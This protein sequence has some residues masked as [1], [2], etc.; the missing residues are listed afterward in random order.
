[1]VSL[2][3]LLFEG[4]V[5]KAPSCS[6]YMENLFSFYS[7]IIRLKSI[8]VDVVSSAHHFNPSIEYTANSMLTMTQ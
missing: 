1:M 6:Q 4:Q 2:I 3:V 8:T 5:M 7:A